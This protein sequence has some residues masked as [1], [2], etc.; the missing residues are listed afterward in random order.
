MIRE[1]ES[2]ETVKA[3]EMVVGP[4]VYYV[5]SSWNLDATYEDDH[6]DHYHHSSG[7]ELFVERFTMTRNPGGEE[8]VD[9]AEMLLGMNETVEERSAAVR[10][11]SGFT[12]VSYSMPDEDPGLVGL[13]CELCN[14]YAPG[15]VA[16]IRYGST[17]D[18]REILNPAVL[19]WSHVIRQ[20]ARA[21]QFA[22]DKV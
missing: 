16:I 8:V 11:A 4:F 9:S 5:P 13:F 22:P 19:L 18:R 1:H 6:I 10:L 14:L 17:I 2:P 21:S 12:M 15:K 20:Y 7:A 3:L